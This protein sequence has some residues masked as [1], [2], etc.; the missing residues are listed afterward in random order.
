M[1]RTLIS[2]PI[3]TPGKFLSMKAIPRRFGW[4][5]HPYLQADFRNPGQSCR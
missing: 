5:V 1:H 4:C 2:R 3:F